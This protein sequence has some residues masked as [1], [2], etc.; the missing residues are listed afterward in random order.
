MADTGHK[1][2]QKREKPRFG[3]LS[4]CIWFLKRGWKTWKRVPLLTLALILLRVGRSLFELF[5]PPVTVEK[6]A[7]GAPLSSLFA[8]VGILAGGLLLTNALIRYIGGNM[9]YPKIAIRSTIVSDLADKMATTSFPNTMD[10]V[11]LR[12]HSRAENAVGGNSAPGEATWGTMEN[13]LVSITGFIIY[14][15]LLTG[16]HPVLIGASAV[17]AA[18]SFF[19]TRHADGWLDRHQKEWDRAWKNRRYS[20]GVAKEPR[21]AKDIRVFSLQGFFKDRADK[22]TLGQRD[23]LVRME[24]A[25]L[26]GDL[27]DLLFFF[28]RNGL[29]YALLTLMAIRGEITVSEFLLYFGAV[30]GFSGWV[31]G[32][33][34]GIS[35]L[36]KQCV[37]LS[38]IRESLSYPEPF[39]FEGGKPIPEEAKKRAEITFDHVSYRYPG[40]EEDS[41]HDVSFT[42]R[43]G[44]KLAVVG[45]NGAG[46][47]TLVRLLTGLLDPTGGK[48]T[49]NGEDIRVYDRR[50]YYRLIA[51]VFQEVMALAVTVGE[52]VA[53]SAGEI[54]R[55]RVRACLE[56]AGLS[57]FLERLPE[58]LDTHLTQEVWLDG[59]GLSGG[60]AQKLLLARAL[61]KGGAVL[62]LDEPTAALDP[63]AESEM[64]RRYAEMTEGRAALYVSHRLASTRFCDRILLLEK[65]VIAEEGDHESLMA[66]GGKYAELFAVQKKY[67]EEGEPA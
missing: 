42:L 9:L 66:K 26:P 38:V 7:N 5:L 40:A 27:L 35:T 52:N 24:R 10:T 57:E 34:G 8:A 23:L 2:K 53:A 50:E 36:R 25:R 6:V 64:Y 21:P 55:E 22:D 29:A 46:K 47:T 44:E 15:L 32:I 1:K 20:V 33:L 51:A 13:L 3:T 67:Y 49:L 65:G 12:L 18:I 45:L 14:L 61:Y 60:E 48:V 31:A 63:I 59:V 54:D 39:V 30:T 28:L 4:T 58:G 16:A 43:S 37:E 11:F 17:M 41:L 62:A 19:V 56:K